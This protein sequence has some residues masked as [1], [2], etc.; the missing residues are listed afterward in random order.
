MGRRWGPQGGSHQ[1]TCLLLPQLVFLQTPESKR[2]VK[3]VLPVAQVLLFD[4][5]NPQILLKDG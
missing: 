4:Q 5:N 2:L 1:L 3:R